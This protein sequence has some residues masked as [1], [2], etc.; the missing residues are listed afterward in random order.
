MSTKKF[1]DIINR[2]KRRRNVSKRIIENQLFKESKHIAYANHIYALAIVVSLVFLMFGLIFLRVA[3][4][5]SQTET[6]G[7]IQDALQ[8]TKFAVE[9]HVWKKLTH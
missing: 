6:I 1:V 7:Y 9:E 4:N 3:T 2:G 5:I 8:Q